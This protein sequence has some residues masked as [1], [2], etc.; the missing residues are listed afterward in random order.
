MRRLELPV[1]ILPA[2][3]DF[4]PAGEDYRW[5]GPNVITKFADRIFRCTICEG[6]YYTWCNFDRPT[7]FKCDHCGKITIHKVT[8]EKA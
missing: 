3:D 5:C 7:F 4:I 8:N 1:I 6:L 2:Y